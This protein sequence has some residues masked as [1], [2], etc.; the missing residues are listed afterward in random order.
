MVKGK[1]SLWE[2][3]RLEVKEKEK[4]TTVI[5]GWQQK[6]PPHMH[7]HFIFIQFQSAPS[8]SPAFNAYISIAM[9]G[10]EGKVADSG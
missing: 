2:G 4:G 9:N 3:L 10:W 7:M 8:M 5:Y 1:A 6:G